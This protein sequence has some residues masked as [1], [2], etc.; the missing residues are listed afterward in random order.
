M[1]SLTQKCK[2]FKPVIDAFMEDEE[3]QKRVEKRLKEK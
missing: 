2:E 1:H 3:I